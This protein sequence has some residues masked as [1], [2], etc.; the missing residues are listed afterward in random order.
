MLD[1]DDHIVGQI[2]KFLVKRPDECEC[3]TGSVEEVRIPKCDVL[4]TARHEL[5]NVCH[6]NIAFNDAKPPVVDGD[7]RAV[8]AQVFTA[9]TGFGVA[10]ESAAIIRPNQLGV[11]VERW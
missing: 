1:L 10:D 4:G 9:S 8:S 5:A 7:H 2:G 3:V 6:N 11:L